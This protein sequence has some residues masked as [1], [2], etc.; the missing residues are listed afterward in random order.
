[1]QQDYFLSKYLTYSEKE[2]SIKINNFKTSLKKKI[3]KN[4]KILTKEKHTGHASYF[5]FP[6]S[7][8]LKSA[9]LN[10]FEEEAA[11]P[12]TSILSELSF[13]ESAPIFTDLGKKD[14]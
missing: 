14:S 13:F 11:V 1:M 3:K 6:N 5:L 4:I 12:S 10:P 9:L 8:F 2:D 7:K